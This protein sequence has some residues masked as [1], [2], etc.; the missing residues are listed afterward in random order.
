MIGLIFPPQWV[1]NH[2]YL[3]PFLLCSRLK[4]KGIECK[5]YDF[6]LLFYQYFVK[7]RVSDIFKD[8]ELFFNHTIYSRTLQRVNDVLPSNDFVSIDMFNSHFK[9][10]AYRSKELWD[11]VKDKHNIFHEI[12]LKFIKD[13][14]LEEYRIVGISIVAYPQL[15]PGLTLAYT[16]KLLN[17]NIKI[18]LGGDM[19]SRIANSLKEEKR[20]WDYVD[21]IICGEGECA[22]DAIANFIKD[23]REVNF[24]KVPNTMT[25]HNNEPFK[26]IPFDFRDYIEA[27]YSDVN[28]NDYLA[29]FPIMTVEMTRG[30]YWSKCAYCET[31]EIPFKTRSVTDVV[32]EVENMYKN[33]GIQHFSFADLAVPPKK[34]F[35]FASEV[36]KKKLPIYWKCMIRPEIIFLQKDLDVLYR[37]G[38]RMVLIG[39][40]S[41][42]HKILKL[43]N[44]G[45]S[46]LVVAKVL[47][48]FRESNIWVHGYFIIG[49]PSETNE[50]IM[51]TLDFIL[52]NN[53]DLNSFSISQFV[54]LRD[55]KFF[56]TPK[57]YNIKIQVNQNDNLKTAHFKFKYNGRIS[58]RKFTHIGNK[59][60]KILK[61][62]PYDYSKWNNLD[63]NHLFLYI[64][65][66]GIDYFKKTTPTATMNRAY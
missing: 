35:H 50:Q 24:Q 9:Y 4:A 18:M 59:I 11:A 23:G 1:P 52:H 48:K 25:K 28:V 53:H 17:P 43:I 60:K 63:I 44:K 2:P 36:A 39:I 21:A 22:I 55:S 49:F 27:D 61:S 54:L 10:K 29:P 12:L 33:Y 6:N 32:N 58:S 56:R 14:K 19:I 13:V 51:E 7:E 41:T 34:M 15:I 26:T 64:T 47:K 3:A 40:E 37:G 31:T 42:N 46:T 8:S 66:N 30:C 20:I 65:Q 16:I 62:H 38:C 5:V 45:T 57:L